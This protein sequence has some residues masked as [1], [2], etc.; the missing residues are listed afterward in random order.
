MRPCSVGLHPALLHSHCSG[1]GVRR[2]EWPA[3]LAGPFAPAHRPCP[4]RA[5]WPPPGRASSHQTQRAGLQQ[6]HMWPTQ[7]DGPCCSPSQASS[8]LVP[9]Q[10]VW[11]SEDDSEAV[12]RCCLCTQAHGGP[13]PGGGGPA[14]AAKWSQAGK[15]CLLS[16]RARRTCWQLPLRKALAQAQGQGSRMQS[17]LCVSVCRLRPQVRRHHCPLP[18]SYPG[19]L[20]PPGQ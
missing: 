10:Q 4:S 8:Q 11:A 2:W 15:Q 3:N 12:P 1:R 18:P 9:T 7:A 14:P 16:G 5:L 6:G 13:Q 19:T 20:L 17:P